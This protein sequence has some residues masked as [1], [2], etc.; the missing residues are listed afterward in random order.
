[1]ASWQV[2]RGMGK[3][4]MRL[5]PSTTANG[6]TCNDGAAMTR[7][8]GWGWRDLKDGQWP[9]R[10]RKKDFWIDGVN[11]ECFTGAKARHILLALAARLKS[12]PDTKH[13][14]TQFFRRLLGRSW[15]GLSWKSDGCE[16]RAA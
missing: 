5:L 12:C 13:V 6:L 1:M 16:R 10:L 7:L 14:Q 3:A 11:K 15:V 8:E 2:G 9:S 4:D